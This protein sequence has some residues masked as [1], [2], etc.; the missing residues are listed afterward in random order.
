[1]KNTNTNKK[2]EVDKFAD[3]SK[4]VF[5]YIF[6]IIIGLSL[7][8]LINNIGLLYFI[9]L[10]IIFMSLITFSIFYLLYRL[11]R[12]ALNENCEEKRK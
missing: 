11:L 6:G 9:Y 8:I 12:L 3:E 7:L 5:I 4:R 2:N 10:K 1:M